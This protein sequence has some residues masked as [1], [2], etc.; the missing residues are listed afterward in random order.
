[1]AVSNMKTK[2]QASATDVSIGRRLKLRRSIL[3]ISQT[4]LGDLL[5]L[6]F[7]QIQKYEKGKNRISA[8]RLYEISK[9]LDVPLDYFYEDFSIDDGKAV[10]KN[11]NCM[12][13]HIEEAEA[14]RILKSYCSISDEKMRKAVLDFMR[15][16]GKRE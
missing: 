16:L 13:F 10:L 11:E 7:Q 12:G 8:A 15:E 14:I 3:G 1:M 4:E 5:D 9:I 2:G 6:T